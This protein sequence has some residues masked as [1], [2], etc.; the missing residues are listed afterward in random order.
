MAITSQYMQIK[1][2]VLSTLNLCTCQSFQYNWKKIKEKK[3][4]SISF[5]YPVI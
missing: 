4:L 1:T 2:I 3:T 5:I